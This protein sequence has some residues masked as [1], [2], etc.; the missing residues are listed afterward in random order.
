MNPFGV[1]KVH[2]ILH[3]EVKLQQA[4]GLF[5]FDILI[6]VVSVILRTFASE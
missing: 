1:V 4:D 6:L 2:I 3:G 5:D